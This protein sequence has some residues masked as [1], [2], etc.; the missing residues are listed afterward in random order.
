MVSVDV[1]KTPIFPLIILLILGN[2]PLGGRKAEFLSLHIGSIK[3][4]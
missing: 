4:G 1:N 2:S 3:N